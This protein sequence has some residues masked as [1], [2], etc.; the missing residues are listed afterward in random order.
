MNCIYE[1]VLLK[2]S[3]SKLEIL[4]L[5]ILEDLT[6]DIYSYGQISARL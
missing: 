5:Y 3:F 4:E 6:K 2:R 1:V